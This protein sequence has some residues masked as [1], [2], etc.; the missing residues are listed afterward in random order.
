MTTDASHDRVAALLGAYALDAVDA[1]DAALVES[2]LESCSACA[3][4][5]ASHREVAAGLAHSFDDPP[6]GLWPSIADQLHG[7]SEPEPT[8]AL[9][10]RDGSRRRWPLIVA[11]AA[12]AVA[13]LLGGFAIVQENRIDR[14]EEQVA[15]TVRDLAEAAL[16][17]AGSQRVELV[18]GDGTRVL[19]VVEGS[20][21][22]FLFADTL[23]RLPAER[24]YQLWGI[25]GERAV[26]VGVLG[27]TPGVVTFTVGDGADSLAVTNE[28]TGGVERTEQAPVV[29][30]DLG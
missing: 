24:S 15:P 17:D 7:S 21:R 6:E 27:A 9:T 29:S 13:A 3:A 1:D 20:G 18:G 19:G 23:P 30:G 12:V 22:G 26:S 14:L 16:A 10:G 11:T 8:R 5:L 4:E 25:T 2:H 28:V